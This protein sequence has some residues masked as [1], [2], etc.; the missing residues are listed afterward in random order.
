MEH[1]LSARRELDGGGLDAEPEKRFGFHHGGRRGKGRSRRWRGRLRGMAG[2]R[3]REDED[4]H[5]LHTPAMARAARV[6]S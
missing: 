2:E 6:S 4:Q 1:G 5:A 3:E